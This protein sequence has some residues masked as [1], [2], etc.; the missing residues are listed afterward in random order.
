MNPCGNHFW[1]H[2]FRENL[3]GEYFIANPK[4]CYSSLEN[5]VKFLGAKLTK[6]ISICYFKNF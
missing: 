2:V 5:K 6:F 1:K 3:V 4:F